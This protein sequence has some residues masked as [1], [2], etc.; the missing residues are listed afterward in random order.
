MTKGNLEPIG[1]GSLASSE[2][3]N[4]NFTYLDDAVKSAVAQIHANDSNFESQLATLNTNLSNRIGDLE[5][6]TGSAISD[7]QE[8]TDAI[9]NNN[10]VSANQS[11]SDTKNYIK[12]NN[13]A[14]SSKQV[15]IQWGFVTGMGQ[16]TEKTVSLKTDFTSGSSYV[17]SGSSSYYQSSGD[18]GSSWRVHTLSSASFKIQSRFEQSSN[19]TIYWVAIGY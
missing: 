5:D 7:L 12:F 17:V 1:Y 18:K 14:D 19:N 8:Q 6:E 2:L 3:L 15:I 9:V 10:P 16:G 4:D 11:F 13:P